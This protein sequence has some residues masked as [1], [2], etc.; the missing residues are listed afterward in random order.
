MKTVEKQNFYTVWTELCQLA[1]RQL[2]LI[3][4]LIQIDPTLGARALLQTE[5]IYAD[6]AGQTLM[7]WPCKLIKADTVIWNH[8]IGRT[9]YLHTPM[10]SNLT[11]YFILPGSHDLSLHSPEIPCKDRLPGIHKQ[12][13]SKHPQVWETDKGPISVVHVPLQLVWKGTWKT[14]VFKSEKLF[15][16]PSPSHLRLTMFSSYIY[17][18]AK[19]EHAFSNLVN[20]TSHFSTDPEIVRQAFQGIGTGLATLVN[21]TGAAIGHIWSG[22]GTGAEHLISGLIKGPL[23]AFLNVAL[24]LALTLLMLYIF[25]KVIIPKLCKDN[26]TPSF[27]L[28]TS[29]TWPFISFAKP[30]TNQDTEIELEALPTNSNKP[31]DPLDPDVTPKPLTRPKTLGLPVGT[32]EVASTEN[33]FCKNR[34]V[35]S[36]TVNDAPTKALIDTGSSISILSWPHLSFINKLA[37]KFNRTLLQIHSVPTSFCAKGITGH[38]LNPIGFTRLK[39]QFPSSTVIHACIVLSSVGD[40]IDVILGMDILCKLQPFTIDLE[41]ALLR[42]NSDTFR[43]ESPYSPVFNLK[44][45]SYPPFSTQISSFEVSSPYPQSVYT[46]F[47]P[48]SKFTEGNA[49]VCYPSLTIL[50]P[51]DKEIP[52]LI[53]NRTDKPIHI[54][55]NK[56]LGFCHPIYPNLSDPLY[57]HAFLKKSSHSYSV[58]TATPSYVNSATIHP[59]V[60]LSDLN[61]TDSQKKELMNLLIE[62]GDIFARG[63]LDLGKSVLVSH[64]IIT[65][66]NLPPVALKP[67]RLPFKD[68]EIIE[69]KVQQMAKAGIIRRS[70]SS[71]SSPALLVPKPGSDEKRLVIDYR[72]LNKRTLNRNRYTLPRVDELIMALKGRSFFSTLDMLSCF[73]Q[74]PLS[75]KS[76]PLTAFTTYSSGLWEFLVLPFGLT[77]ASATCQRLVDEVFR[78]LKP[79]PFGPPTTPHVVS[80]LDDVLV[81]STGPWSRHLA[82]LRATFEAIRSA[83]LKLRVSKCKFVREEIPYLGVL[84]TKDGVLPDPKKIKV[85][86][87]YE[88]P[89]TQ[90]SLRRW[91]GICNYYRRHVPHFSSIAK[92]LNNLLK[93]NTPYNWTSECESA[94]QILKKCLISPPILRFPDLNKKFIVQSDASKT[95]LGGCLAQTAPDK[96]GKLIEHVIAYTSRSLTKSET[97]DPIILLEALAI[98][99]C[100]D[101]FHVYLAGGTPFEIQTDHISLRTLLDTKIPSPRLQRIA[102][103]I[104]AYN[105]VITYKKGISCSNADF[106]SRIHQTD[107]VFEI[108][109]VAEQ[110]LANVQKPRTETDPCPINIDDSNTPPPTPSNPNV[111]LEMIDLP[112]D[113]I[114]LQNQDPY[115]GPIIN[116]LCNDKL[117]DDDQ[118]ARVV[119]LQADYFTL[120]EGILYRIEP[121]THYHLKLAVPKSL[122]SEIL[123][124][125]H[126]HIL[127]MHWGIYKTY[128]KIKVHYYFPCMYKVVA[129]YIKTCDICQRKRPSKPVCSMP[130]TPIPPTQI[131]QRVTMDCFGPF[132]KSYP[133]EYSYLI[134]FV[135]TFTRYCFAACLKQQSAKECAK[136]FVEQV[137]LKA[138]ICE[139]LHS[140]RGAA[141]MSQ[142]MQ[143]V[144][145]MLQVKKIFGC[146]Y[147]S[148]C[149]GSVE[150]AGKQL[151]QLLSLYIQNSGQPQNWPTYVPYLIYTY[152][153]SINTTTGDSP[154][155]L[156]H[157]FDPIPPGSP[158]S[159]QYVSPY[160]VDTEDFRHQLQLNMMYSRQIAKEAMLKSQQAQIKFYNRKSKPFDFY[161]SQLVLVYNPRLASHEQNQPASRHIRFNWTGIFRIKSLTPKT[162]YIYNLDKPEKLLHVSLDRL[163]PYFARDPT[164]AAL[165][166]N[167]EN[168]TPNSTAQNKNVSPLNSIPKSTASP[169]HNYN[170]RS[171]NN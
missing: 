162:A 23:Q 86:V 22:L 2:S 133:D 50:S 100:L 12:K 95:G 44:R 19:M 140:D 38:Q 29:T 57:C 76:I 60:D 149:Q 79:K 78:H 43:F 138:G 6:L 101:E 5:S 94:F 143:E 161:E 51:N 89:K 155:F 69:E 124:L 116:Y 147:H 8:T 127:S 97:K 134:V 20:Y 17:H 131:M 150:V 112:K 62:F 110:T 154:H 24:I 102:T 93:Q 153:T 67:H 26:T 98:E 109:T 152:N 159:F 84:I 15:E 73:H 36:I 117:P 52:I 119:L 49:L 33:D 27:P 125:C 18:L 122:Q 55:K 13:N 158:L 120:V 63:P 16:N 169:T 121:R 157:C 113:I 4:H 126:S 103:K 96:N 81:A 56:I 137:V 87:D 165:T 90:K 59:N 32:F 130:L 71:Y 107:A 40:F 164:L 91:L 54:A 42:I 151:K 156:F 145:Q 166:E 136:A 14:F 31:S 11:L 132:I 139:T 148:Q 9:C 39:F 141:F 99:H 92:P 82:D 28:T 48:N 104:Q 25:A 1:R 34:L 85:I 41:K 75:E 66:P 171:R 105:Y 21:G 144:C 30:D 135:E 10:F 70:T 146:A 58:T 129:E 115:F 167:I 111:P 77:G 61:I 168:K 7:I 80:Y 170:L 53:V 114:S 65:D 37:E 3:L 72:A 123:Y 88:N 74:I 163:K 46:C 128:N 106:L 160:I 68:R 35:I 45:K 118:T 83:N 64:D 108:S 47:E 142:L